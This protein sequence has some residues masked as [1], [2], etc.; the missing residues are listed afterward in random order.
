MRV[1]QYLELGSPN[2]DPKTEVLNG[3]KNVKIHTIGRCKIDSV[4]DEVLLYIRLLT[5]LSMLM[6]FQ[7]VSGSEILDVANLYIKKNEVRVIKLGKSENSITKIETETENEKVKIKPDVS[8]AYRNE[9]KKLVD[10]YK[11]NKTIESP[12]KLKIILRDEN[13]SRSATTYR[14]REKRSRRTDRRVA[15]KQNN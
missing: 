2:Y 7:A 1:D 11:P 14:A 10:S 12:I 3:P 4:I 5:I 13:L 15:K 8:V 9:V 6:K